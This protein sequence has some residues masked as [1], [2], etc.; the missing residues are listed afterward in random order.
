MNTIDDLDIESF[1]KKLAMACKN[2]PDGDGEFRLPTP[3]E[4]LNFREMQQAIRMLAAENKSLKRKLKGVRLARK[5]DAEKAKETLDWFV[6]KM[7]RSLKSTQS[8]KVTAMTIYLKFLLDEIM[9]QLIETGKINLGDWID[10]DD[11]AHKKWKE[12]HK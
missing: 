3:E 6:D 4:I 11:S 1:K 12:M 9:E 7:S 10:A 8:K 5:R 2:L